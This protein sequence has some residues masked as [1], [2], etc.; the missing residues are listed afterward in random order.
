MNYQVLYQ[1]SYSLAVIKLSPNESIRAESGAMVSMTPNV[2]LASKLGGSGAGGLWGAVK[3]LAGGESI[4]GSTFTAKDSA[5]EVTL[6]PSLPGDIKAIQ[7]DGAIFLQS[8]AYMACDASLTI[9]TKWGG[10]KTFFSRE[11]LFL[12]K[13]S[14]RGTLLISSY[15]AIHERNLSGGE[16]Y[17]VDTSHIVAFDQ[18]VTYAV[19]KAAKGIL[20]SMTSG[21]GLVCEYTGPGRLFIQTRNLGALASEIHKLLPKK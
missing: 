6:S 16:R 12:V 18:T 17:V 14:G 13:V 21:E 9:D 11:G 15:G 1:P 10:A 7:V 19:R 5:G 20:N 4:F 2:E 3:S 8:G